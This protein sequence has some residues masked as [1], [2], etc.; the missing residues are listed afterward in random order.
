MEQKSRVFD[1]D[2]YL[3]GTAQHA[4]YFIEDD[5][6]YASINGRFI[7]AALGTARPDETVRNLLRRCGPRSQENH[8]NDLSWS[9]S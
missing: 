2:M 6:I 9:N 8:D 3:D 5:K 7:I 4:S 1:V